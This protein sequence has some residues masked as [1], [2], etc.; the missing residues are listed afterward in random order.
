MTRPFE[1]SL[2]T[3]AAA[4]SLLAAACGST[5]DHAPVEPRRICDGSAA[6]R[7]AFTFGLGSGTLES[8][9]NVLYDIGFDFVFVD[10]TCHYWVASPG[11]TDDAYALWRPYREGVLSTGQERLLHD[12]VSYDDIRQNEVAAS[13]DGPT[14]FDQSFGRFWDGN[15][16]VRCNMGF[17]P[18]PHWPMRD[19]LYAAGT[20]LT[21][22]VRI[23]V[24]LDVAPN[25][26]VYEWPLPDGPDVYAVPY[27]SPESRRVADPEQANA[28][29]AIQAQAIRDGEKN[30][31]DFFGRSIVE[32]KGFVRPAG[33]TYVMALRDDLPFADENGLWSPP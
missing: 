30:P 24:G 11:D 22:P 6:I 12:A 31:F 2:V 10:G 5:N 13:C 33:Q 29:R 32:P 25:Q 21:G 19:V 18:P 1:R 4:A 27:N 26:P 15:T 7:L 3:M 28:L 8:Y 20:D 16:F 23:Q 14:A 9:T 17:D